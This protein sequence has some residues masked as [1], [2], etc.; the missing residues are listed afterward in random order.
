MVT[1]H[2]NQVKEF[3]EADKDVLW[4]TFYRR[5]LWWCFSSSKVK[6]EAGGKYRDVEG[7]WRDKDAK[8]NTLTFDHLS[9][10]LLST[11]GFR[12]TICSVREAEYVKNKVNGIVEKEVEDAQLAYDE[13][14]L[15]V[16]R[17]I[18]E[19]HPKDLEI[20]VDL[21]FRQAGWKRIGELG[22]TQKD[23]DLELITPITQEKFY[24]QVKSRVGL[25]EFERYRERFADMKGYSRCYFIVNKPA[26]NL[27]SLST[28]EHDVQL[29]LGRQLAQLSVEYGLAAWII[30]K[31]A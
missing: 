10:A 30:S 20:L 2:L 1:R 31:A 23:I 15:K 11:Q 19:L 17:L 3:Y 24:V 5:K 22:K 28:D 29:I 12:G 8:G 6:M 7:S 25:D 4:I 26:K 27:E 21:I 18:G 14:V 9:G 16:E 13:L